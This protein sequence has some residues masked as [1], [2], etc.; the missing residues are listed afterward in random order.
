MA[1]RR[2]N[3][4]WLKLIKVWLVHTCRKPCIGDLVLLLAFIGEENP[5]FVVP[6]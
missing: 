2:E 5:S 4:V 1:L 6:E 3:A